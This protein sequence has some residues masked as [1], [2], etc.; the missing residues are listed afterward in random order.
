MCQS[1]HRC[2]VL[3]RY[4]LRIVDITELNKTL[5]NNCF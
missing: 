4:S 2:F 5:K 3:Y 1:D